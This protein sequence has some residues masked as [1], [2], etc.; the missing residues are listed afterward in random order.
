MA[1]VPK[2]EEALDPNRTKWKYVYEFDDKLLLLD[3]ELW[4]ETAFIDIFVQS[5]ACRD[6]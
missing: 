1:I 6:L 3:N 2:S 4:S 5:P